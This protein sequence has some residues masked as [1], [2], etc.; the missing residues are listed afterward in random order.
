MS[1]M[2]FPVLVANCKVVGSLYVV[3]RCWNFEQVLIAPVPPA[4][5]LEK[6]L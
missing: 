3:P 5:L 1:S 2:L 4:L 6:A